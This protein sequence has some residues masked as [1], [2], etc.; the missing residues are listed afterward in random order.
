MVESKSFP[1][2][3]LDGELQIMSFRLVYCKLSKISDSLLMEELLGI[4]NECA[5]L[6][7]SICVSMVNKRHAT[8]NCIKMIPP[9]GSM[10]LF[11][12]NNMRKFAIQFGILWG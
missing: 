9:K 4:L 8:L 10:M 11:F 7:S 6:I 3:K 5:V 1:S 12:E 2:Y